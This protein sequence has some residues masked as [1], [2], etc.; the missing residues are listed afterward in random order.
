MQ[1]RA[2][3]LCYCMGTTATSPVRA[4]CKVLQLLALAHIQPCVHVRQKHI[5]SDRR[6]LTAKLIHINKYH[7]KPLRDPSQHRT[8]SCCDGG[9][10]RVA[11]R[12]RSR[13]DLAHPATNVVALNPPGLEHG[14]RVQWVCEHELRVHVC[15][16]ARG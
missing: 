8:L 6:K 9:S 13:A 14:Q 11:V 4:T 2:T 12:C 5:D 1:E 16:P 15:V 3:T 7:V 10:A